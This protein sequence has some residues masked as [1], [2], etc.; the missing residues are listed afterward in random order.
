MQAALAKYLKVDEWNVYKC[1]RRMI[2]D[3]FEESVISIIMKKKAA[4]RRRLMLPPKI[5]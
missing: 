1:I 3:E 2:M 5:L 4:R